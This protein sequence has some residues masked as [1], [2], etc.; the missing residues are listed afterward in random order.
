MM[1]AAYNTDHYDH[2]NDHHAYKADKGKLRAALVLQ[3]FPLALRAISAVS[4]FGAEKYEAHSWA[5][6]PDALPRY[7][8]ALIRHQ[9]QHFAGETLDPESG[10]AHYAHFAWGVL[11]TL[12]MMEREANKATT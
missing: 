12:E 7:T 10:L 8:D 11:A 9:L 4:T 3:D 1:S 6:V 2:M 5:K